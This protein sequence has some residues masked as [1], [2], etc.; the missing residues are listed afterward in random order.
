LVHQT[1]AQHRQ[2]LVANI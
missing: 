1:A 2:P